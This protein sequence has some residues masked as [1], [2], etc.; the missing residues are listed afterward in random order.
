MSITSPSPEANMGL[1]FRQVRDAMWAEMA[2]EMALAM[3]EKRRY[4]ATDKDLH[5]FQFI[6]A[7]AQANPELLKADYDH[8]ASR[9][10]FND[11][12]KYVG[13]TRSES[14]VSLNQL[15]TWLK[16]KMEEYKTRGA[17]G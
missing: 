10:L 11:F 5:F 6:G 13:Q 17:V 16:G 8:W 9:G 15:K 1:I 2:R 14:N 4:P 3:R 7:L 12:E